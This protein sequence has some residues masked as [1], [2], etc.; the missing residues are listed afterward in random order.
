MSDKLDLNGVIGDALEGQGDRNRARRDEIL[1][2]TFTNPKRCKYNLLP[3]EIVVRGKVEI[4][5][6][7]FRP[8]RGDESHVGLPEA[9]LLTDV[10]GLPRT[11]IGDPIYKVLKGDGQIMTR[12]FTTLEIR[13]GK[14]VP[15]GEKGVRFVEE[16]A[17]TD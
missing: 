16:A 14:F 8:Y 6:H 1:L 5:V 13:W 17:M 4:A 2:E 10:T 3:L 12:Q 7:R 9:C 15:N 11:E